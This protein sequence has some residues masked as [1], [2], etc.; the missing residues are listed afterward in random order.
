MPHTFARPNWIIFPNLVN[1]NWCKCIRSQSFKTHDCS[2]WQSPSIIVHLRKWNVKQDLLFNVPFHWTTKYICCCHVTLFKET[3]G[4]ASSL[5]ASYPTKNW[6]WLQLL[7]M[8]FGITRVPTN[9]SKTW[10]FLN[11]LWLFLCYLL[12]WLKQFEFCSNFYLT[13]QADC[14]CNASTD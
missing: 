1:L 12:C 13:S 9:T 5:K 11:G 2:D 14:Y 8:Y 4:Q 3:A 6:L 7:N 10:A